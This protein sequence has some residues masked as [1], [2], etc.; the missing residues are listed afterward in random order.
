MK[1]TKIQLIRLIKEELE[2]LTTPTQLQQHV[3]PADQFPTSVRNDQINHN[4]KSKRL[5]IMD[6]YDLESVIIDV[7]K[8]YGAMGFDVE[9]VLQYMRKNML[10]EYSESDLSM[11]LGDMFDM[12]ILELEPFEGDYYVLARE[13]R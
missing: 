7:G 2:G 4:V 6:N 1:I 10:E 13:H 5:T 11:V 3:F 12:G 9:H 8:M